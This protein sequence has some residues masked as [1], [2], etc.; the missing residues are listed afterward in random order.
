MASKAKCTINDIKEYFLSKDNTPCPLTEKLVKAGYQQRNGGYI[1]RAIR[2]G[3]EV[4]YTH[5]M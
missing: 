5:N 1:E 4:D 2:E 3:V